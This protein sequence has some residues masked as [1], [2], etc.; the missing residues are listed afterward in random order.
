LIGELAALG[1]AITW[2]FSSVFYRKALSVANPFQANLIRFT[3][4]SIV[5]VAFF[6]AVGKIGILVSLPISVSAI[7]IL[8]GVIGLVL[9]DTLYMFAL[10]AVGIARAVPICYTY[11]LF[12]VLIAVVINGERITTFV[13]FGAV[14][15]VFG[16]WLISSKKAHSD[17]MVR[18]ASRMGYGV[19]VSA[20][21]IWSVSIALVN[22]AVTSPGVI[23]LDGILAV[24]SVRLLS[25]WIVLLALAPVF[26]REF[27]FI[28]VCWQTWLILASGGLVALALGGYLLSFSFLYTQAARAVPISSTTP[29]FSVVAGIAI[30]HETVTPRLILGSLIIVLGIF[31]LFVY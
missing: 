30:L 14:C 15:I 26:D 5:L 13:A 28:K 25:T 22:Y 20:A 29:F 3:S 31:L 27:E 11:P 21:I 16:T 17:T 8:S 4:V 19:A 10:R 18:T 23:G 2:T 7:T 9:G 6:V 12:N 24:T 1:A